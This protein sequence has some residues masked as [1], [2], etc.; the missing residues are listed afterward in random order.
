MNS[1]TSMH[2]LS[3]PVSSRTDL[4]GV[5]GR[6]KGLPIILQ[7]AAALLGL[8]LLL[9]LLLIVGLLIRAESRGSCFYSQVRV[10]KYGRH[11]RMYKF[12]SMYLPSD[13]NYREPS[14][15]SS[16]RAGICKK[17]HA[18]PRVTRVGRFIRKYSIDELPQLFNI[19]RG[20]MLLIG[21]RPA[22]TSEVYQYSASALPRL[23]CEAG[24]TG[25]WQISGR[26]ETSFEQQVELDTR[27]IREQS[28]GSDIRML[29]ATVPCVL[30]A[31]GAY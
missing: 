23:H 16:D 15:D 6:H 19:V 11:F 4:S 9:P 3:L 30:A 17:F 8:L 25:L 26:A 5:D 12:R 7:R 20:D 10:G 27:Y 21:P 29:L 31:R 22:L 28:I 18:D 24:L 13:P 1:L 14:P 2:S